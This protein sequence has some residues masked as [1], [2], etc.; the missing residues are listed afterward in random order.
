MQP[1]WKKTW[2]ATQED[3]D[4]ERSKEPGEATKGQGDAQKSNRVLPPWK[5]TWSAAQKD[6]EEERKKETSTSA[7][8]EAKKAEDLAYL[9]KSAE[10]LQ[11][12]PAEAELAVRAKLYRLQRA[13][14][15]TTTANSGKTVYV[16]EC[17]DEC[18]FQRPADSELLA[19]YEQGQ[20]C[21]K[22]RNLTAM[23]GLYLK[24][25]HQLA[26][27]WNRSVD[28]MIK[29]ATTVEKQRPNQQSRETFYR[30]IVLGGK[31]APKA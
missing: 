4:K 6:N 17:T 25:A 27:K 26:Q 1:P 7:E 5:T 15:E 14:Y 24:K 23:K 16:H 19:T 22:I 9:Q 31:E 2:K 13:W 29:E 20:L 8:D 11:E 3:K 12:T 28:S 18:R 30:T 10:K 21:V